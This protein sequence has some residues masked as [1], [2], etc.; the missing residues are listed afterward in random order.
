MTKTIIPEKRV[1][2]VYANPFYTVQIHQL[3]RDQECPR[4]ISRKK[5]ISTNEKMIYE[6]GK[7]AWLELLLEALEGK[8]LKE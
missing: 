6:I 7:R 3:F 5:W 8:Y 2:R 4:L 1:K